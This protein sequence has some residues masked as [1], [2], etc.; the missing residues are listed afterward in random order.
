MAERAQTFC[1]EEEKPVEGKGRRR[2]E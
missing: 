2:P 1:D